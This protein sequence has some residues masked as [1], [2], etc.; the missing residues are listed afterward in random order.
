[1]NGTNEHGRTHT[2]SD[3]EM[4]E[5][6]ELLHCNQG[7]LLSTGYGR[8]HAHNEYSIVVN[9]LLTILISQDL[10]NIDMNI[11]NFLMK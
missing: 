1:M 11:I 8:L 4:S 5:T 3:I 9:K 7:G 10:C 2:K 6:D